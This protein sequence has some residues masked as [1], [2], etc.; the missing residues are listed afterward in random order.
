MNQKPLIIIS[1]VRFFQGGSIV[2]VNDC[3]TFLSENLSDKY[4]IIA[5]VYKKDLYSA[6]ANIEFIE[7]PK[8][9]K[10]IFYRLYYEYFYFNTFS[11]KQQPLL[12]LSMQDSTPRVKASIRALY[13]HNPLLYYK[14]PLQLFLIQ[15]R[16]GFMW[17]LYKTVYTKNIKQNNFIIVQQENMR[18]MLA[19]KFHLPKEKIWIFPP[20]INDYK[21]SVLPKN[22]KYSFLFPATALAFKNY[23]V[24]F[25]ACNILN[26]TNS[27]YKFFLTVKGNE[28][29]YL[30]SLKRKYSLPQ[31][32]FIGFLERSELFSLYNNTDCM[33]FPS[34]METWGLPL[35]EFSLQD[36]PIICADLSYARETLH[37][38]DKVKF[39]DPNDAETLAAYMLQAMNEELLF[40]KTSFQY[41]EPNIQN[42]KDLFD[43]ILSKTL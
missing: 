41:S 27:N 18:A 37:D 11:K 22:E 35:S 33:I 8:A 3:L 4:R 21:I 1:A 40:D 20:E 14:H 13:Y 34:F 24:I 38:Y 7:F 26:K 5:L 12:W 36:K 16:L 25:K 17:W 28:N 9:R 6:L 29:R 19:E 2:I 10:N 15:W 30:R 42:W 32:E 23:K 39:F 31:I 43:K